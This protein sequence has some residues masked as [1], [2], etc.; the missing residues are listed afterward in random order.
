MISIIIPYKNAMPF[1]EDC[2]KSIIDQT[3]SN[4]ELIL[5]NDHSN[6]NSENIAEKYQLT[7]KRIKSINSNG[8]GIIAALISGTEII[9]GDFITRMDAD[10]IMKNDKL[11]LMR[12]KLIYNGLG[13]VCV[14]GVKYFSSNK[15]LESG[16]I[17]YSKWLNQLTY[18]ENNF[19][20]IFK[21][22]TIPSPCWMM[23]MK[24][25]KKINQ[26]NDLNYPED[27]NFAFKL[28]ENN[29]KI[30]SVK[31]EI[32]LWRDHPK[33]TSRVDSTY[34]YKNFLE[35]KIKYLVSREK[36]SFERLVVWGAGNKGKLLA[37]KLIEKKIEFSWMTENINKINKDIYG[38]KINDKGIFKQDFKKLIIC[39]IS[40][41]LFQLPVSDKMNRFISFY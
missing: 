7:D 32:H 33:R 14:G 30:T 35:L 12:K 41:P 17:K 20:D 18:S 21:E 19:L 25:F 22:C 38:I 36:K 4:F 3:Y 13:H 6:D 40:D 23:Y 11:E 39:C 8:D 26:F 28:W 5:V 16:Y 24:D 1:F 29:F 27:Y 37:K 15:N 9:K 31:K 2:L 10:D 34:D